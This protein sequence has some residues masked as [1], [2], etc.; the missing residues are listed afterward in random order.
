MQDSSMANLADK[1]LKFC[2]NFLIQCIL[3]VGSFSS[4]QALVC[5]FC[6]WLSRFGEKIH[7]IAI[8]D[9]LQ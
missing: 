1:S 4:F 3:H 5:E 6:N 8:V 2:Q 9:E 7:F